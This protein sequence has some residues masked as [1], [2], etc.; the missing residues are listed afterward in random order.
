MV[1]LRLWYFPLTFPPFPY[2]PLHYFCIRTHVFSSPDEHQL[3]YLLLQMAALPATR[4]HS[5]S[6]RQAVPFGAHVGCSLSP[7]KAH[8]HSCGAARHHP[9]GRSRPVAPCSHAGGPAALAL[10]PAWHLGKGPAAPPGAFSRLPLPPRGS[11]CTSGGPPVCQPQGSPV[12]VHTAPTPL[13]TGLPNAQ[14]TEQLRIARPHGSQSPNR[15]A[16]QCTSTWLPWAHPHG[17]HL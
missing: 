13:T 17:S 5:W 8:I 6:S 2:T 1:R 12:C 16:P 3:P 4:M 14:T 10:L 11:P 15:R 9:R 7:R